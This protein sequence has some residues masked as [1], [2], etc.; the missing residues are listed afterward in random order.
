MAISSLYK[1][2]GRIC[3]SV[4]N[5][6]WLTK[7]L[8]I[9]R[10]QE[11]KFAATM[12]VTS[13]VS[14]DLVGCFLY[15]TQSWN[16]KK[17]PEDKRKFVAMTD[18]MNGIIMVG[19]QFLVGMI[20]DKKLT[21]K[22]LGKNLTG[23][24]V[25]K[26]TKVE[27]TISTVKAYSSDNIHELAKKAVQEKAAELKKLGVNV[28]KI[29][30]AEIGKKAVK[31]FGKGGAKYATVVS[32]FGLLVTAIATTAL[33]KRTLAPLASTPLASWFKG[34]YLDDAKKPGSKKA[35]KADQKQDDKK[36][37][38]QDEMLDH[39]VAPWN[40]TNQD[41]DKATFNKTATK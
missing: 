21:P 25:D 2:A 40:Y 36:V 29:D 27:S 7:K 11:A 24:V 5:Q 6:K 13:I 4:A 38:S 35:S 3:E 20:I 28:E 18:L 34:R 15:T 16:N 17:I 41:G 30:V 12:L 33:T 32:G 26:D 39:T 9:G 8:E 14:K 37:K 10:T 1:G 23:T 19:G 22:L 31:K